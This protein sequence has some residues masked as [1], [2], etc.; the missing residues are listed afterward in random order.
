M[1]V[2]NTA[3]SPQVQELSAIDAI[4]EVAARGR[5]LT[6]RE[7]I[8]IGQVK[9][10]L[11]TSRS[12]LRTAFGVGSPIVSTWPNAETQ[13]PKEMDHATLIEHVNKLD[14]IVDSVRSNALAAL[15]KNQD[16]R[17]FLGHGRSPLWRELKDFLVDRLNL[18]WDEFNREAVAGVA[19]TERLT[20]MLESA[21]FAFLIMTAEDEHADAMMHA[22]EN[23]VHEVGLFQGKLGMRKAIILLE[24]D[25]QVFSNIHGLSYISFPQGQISAAFEDIRRVLE[26]EELTRAA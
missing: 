15:R 4:A 6:D 1:Q 8:S 21:A 9:M 5:R 3:A 23:V 17:I 2:S 10:W 22:R 26:R 24:D 18:P 14:R 19:T 16:K 25:C 13:V 12:K 20:Q 7:D 11:G